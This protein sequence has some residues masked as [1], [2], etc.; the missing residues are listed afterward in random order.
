MFYAGNESDEIVGILG[1]RIPL[2]NVDHLS[3][4]SPFPGKIR[5]LRNGSVVEEKEGVY[6]FRSAKINKTGVYR[7]EVALSIDGKWVPWIYTNPIYI[8]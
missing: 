2:E 1:D 7:I 5:L 4:V 8:D 3:V 6:D